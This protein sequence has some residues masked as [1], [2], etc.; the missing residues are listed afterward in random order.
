MIH[1]N[2]DFRE[3]RALKPG[4]K[5][6]EGAIHM[7]LYSVERVL[8]PRGALKKESLS[9]HILESLTTYY[10]SWTDEKYGDNPSKQEL[11]E[12]L[13]ENLDQEVRIA[14]REFTLQS[15]LNR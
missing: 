8:H 4:E 5:P 11:L 2:Y 10:Q 3:V 13:K 6:P 15:T 7:H 1:C 9:A 14:W 12:L